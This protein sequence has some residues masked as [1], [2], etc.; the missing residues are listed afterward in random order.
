MERNNQNIE[1]QIQA[2]LAA[3]ENQDNSSIATV[4]QEFSVPEQQL[5]AQLNYQ[6]F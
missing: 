4:A 1:T 2:S 6:Q 3:I 5:R